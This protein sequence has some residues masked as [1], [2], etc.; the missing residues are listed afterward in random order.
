MKF[1]SATRK[2]PGRVP[3]AR[4]LAACALLLAAAMFPHTAAAYDGMTGKGGIPWELDRFIIYTI[5]AARA[6]R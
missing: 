5:R 4:I 2:G 6:C 3:E 1:H